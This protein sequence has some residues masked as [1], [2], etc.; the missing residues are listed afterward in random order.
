LIPQDKGGVF[1]KDVSSF[2]FPITILGSGAGSG[3]WGYVTGLEV[4]IFHPLLGCFADAEY[5]L[6]RYP[7][8]YRNVAG[9]PSV[10]SGLLQHA[11]DIKI[12]RTKQQIVFKMIDFYRFVDIIAI[13]L[14]K[15]F[16]I[17]AKSN[18]VAEMEP[19]IGISWSQFL[20]VL[21]SYLVFAFGATQHLVEGLYSRE[22]LS[23]Q[24]N[25]FM[26]FV[27]GSNCASCDDATAL[28]LP[29]HIIEN[30]RALGPRMTYPT[31]DPRTG[32]R[33]MN[34]PLLYIP[35]LGAFSQTQLDPSV[36]VYKDKAGNNQNVFTNLSQPTIS[37]FDGTKGNVPIQISSAGAITNDVR[38]MME[39]I[40]Q[41]SFGSIPLDSLGDGKG[42][43]NALE[44]LSMTDSVVVPN[45]DVV[46]GQRVRKFTHLTETMVGMS[47]KDLQNIGDFFA[48]PL[49]STSSQT[50][51][52]KEAWDQV[53]YHWVRPMFPVFIGP[54]ANN[55][56]D[57]YTVQIYGNEPYQINYKTS[58]NP[59]TVVPSVGVRNSIIAD[60]CIQGPTSHASQLVS[61]Y[62]F[63]S[64][65]GRG[66]FLSN[67][68][69]NLIS[70][71]PI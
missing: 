3:A 70:K 40:R 65:G 16:A 31:I 27:V 28:E 33:N 11:A 22:P 44:V 4:P 9:D 63:W 12:L 52:I 29:V 47:E 14:R 46:K 15:L 56:T 66:G 25:I 35:V 41:I 43:I 42:G 2:S 64:K 38:I 55:N 61:L 21:R 53:Q 6:V 26:P 68:V 23:A 19:D 69:G 36:Y 57:R 17:A 18:L 20:L 71:I 39:R 8:Q 50:P 32:K 37:L 10:V 24:E 13:W 7:K 45:S 30:I 49:L 62:D 5:K 58:E 51:I 54:G 67:L 48:T 59:N 34:D 60:M 1:N